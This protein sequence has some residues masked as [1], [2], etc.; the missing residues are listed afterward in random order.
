MVMCGTFDKH[1]PNAQKGI[2]VVLDV[3]RVCYKNLPNRDSKMEMDIQTP[4]TDAREGQFVTECGLSLRSL[5]H[6]HILK[7][8]SLTI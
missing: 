7:K 2:A 8:S 4:G 6:H 5:P 1:L 3:E